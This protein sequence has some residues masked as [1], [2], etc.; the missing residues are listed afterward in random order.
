MILTPTITIK[1][2]NMADKKALSEVEILRKE[3]E[4]AG[5]PII[6][7]PTVSVSQE[8]FDKIKPASGNEIAKALDQMVE[9]Q[10]QKSKPTF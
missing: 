10:K 5:I 8:E 4:D 7:I 3:F 1:G 6:N 9:K 2:E